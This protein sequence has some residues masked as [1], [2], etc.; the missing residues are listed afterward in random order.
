MI[1]ILLVTF[2]HEYRIFVQYLNAMVFSYDRLV[3]QTRK[4]QDPS[5]AYGQERFA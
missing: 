3:V 1:Y 2:L 5:G 4:H